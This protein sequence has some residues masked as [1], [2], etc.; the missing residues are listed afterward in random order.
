MDLL[1][2]SVGE[3]I[4]LD[5]DDVTEITYPKGLANPDSLYIRTKDGKKYEIDL[6]EV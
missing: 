1:I 5:V 6:K 3:A 2:Y 4:A